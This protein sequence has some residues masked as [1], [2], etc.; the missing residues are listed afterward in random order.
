MSDIKNES[1]VTTKANGIQVNVAD[2][3]DI[4]LAKYDVNGGKWIKVFDK[5]PASY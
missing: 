1:W 5:I 4:V 3:Q 2:E